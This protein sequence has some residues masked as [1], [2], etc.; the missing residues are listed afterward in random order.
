MRVTLGEIYWGQAL[1]FVGA[2]WLG[3]GRAQ[4]RG[5]PIPLWTSYVL[6]A[7]G[8]AIPM[9]GWYLRRPGQTPEIDRH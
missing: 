6:L 1:V 7:A 5:F 3:E 4:W 8:I 9:L 2:L